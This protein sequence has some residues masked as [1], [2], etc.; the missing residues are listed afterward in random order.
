MSPA[1]KARH[2]GYKGNAFHSALMP[3]A[4]SISSLVTTGP[5]TLVLH[6]AFFVALVSQRFS[7]KCRRAPDPPILSNGARVPPS[8][9]TARCQPP[10][11]SSSIDKPN[12]AA[13]G[14]PPH[15]DD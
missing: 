6:L 9:V 1:R 7:F 15:F 10:E 14:P 5:F 3:R 2:F 13:V 11:I 4:W 8:V 12:R